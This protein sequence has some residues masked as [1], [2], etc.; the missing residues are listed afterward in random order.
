MLE[1]W[2]RAAACLAGLAVL[3]AV[4]PPAHSDHRTDGRL[5]RSAN[6]AGYGWWPPPAPTGTVVGKVERPTTLDQGCADTAGS[7]LGMR[8]RSPV[9]LLGGRHH[10]S[11]C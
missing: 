6:G 9:L 2:R 8:W 5:A 7:W 11:Y 4:A 1:V 10:P 3:V